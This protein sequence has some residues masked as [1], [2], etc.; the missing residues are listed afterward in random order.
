MACICQLSFEAQNGNACPKAH[1][2]HGKKKFRKLS[3][4]RMIKVAFHLCQAQMCLVASWQCGNASSAPKQPLWKQ[5]N[6]TSCCLENQVGEEHGTGKC[7]K[8]R[9]I[10]S[11][12][13]RSFGAHN[14]EAEH[15][16]QTRRSPAGISS[17]PLFPD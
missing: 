9:G 1:P 8:S 2:A 6:A 4:V 14:G 11:S 17:F 16:P 13:Q 12:T 10:Y 15:G 3:L 5:R 7:K